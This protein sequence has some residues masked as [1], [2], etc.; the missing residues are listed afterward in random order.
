MKPFNDYSDIR[1]F[2][3][4]GG[5]RIPQEQLKRELGYAKSLQLNST[6]IWLSEREYRKDPTDFLRK[7]TAFVETAWEAGISTMPILFNG[8]GLHPGDLEQGYEEYAKKLHK[9]CGAGSAGRAWA[10][11][12]GCDE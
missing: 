7:L 12:V 11:Y 4:S 8:N 9:G 1:G 3:Y 2:C 6:R 5:Y 10:A